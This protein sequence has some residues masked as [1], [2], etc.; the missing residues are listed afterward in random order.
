MNPTKPLLLEALFLLPS[1]DIW[2]RQ[3]NLPVKPSRPQQS[4][5]KY[6][7]SVCTWQ[8]YY[9]CSRAETW[10]TKTSSLWVSIHIFVTTL[11]V[12]KTVNSTELQNQNKIFTLF[13]SWTKTNRILNYIVCK[14]SG[15]ISVFFIIFAINYM[16]ICLIIF[17]MPSLIQTKQNKNLPCELPY[18]GYNITLCHGQFNNLIP[19]SDLPS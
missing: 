7:R 5:I 3:V 18:F 2:R 4:R 14:Q 11:T 12:W 19:F 13:Y 15:L 8:Y 10:K 17:P 16:Y 6:I 1:F 9:I